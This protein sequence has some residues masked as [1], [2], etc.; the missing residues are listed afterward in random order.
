MKRF[1]AIAFFVTNSLFCMEHFQPYS[2]SPPRP[3]KLTSARSKQ[4]M[5]LRKANDRIEYCGIE[6]YVFQ[7][8]EAARRLSTNPYHQL[9]V[10]IIRA[11]EFEKISKT[12][13]S[14]DER[15]MKNILSGNFI[16]MH[17]MHYDDPSE[18]PHYDFL[19]I[20][21]PNPHKP[22]GKPAHDIP[23]NLPRISNELLLSTLTGEEK[24]RA[25]QLIYQPKEPLQF[26]LEP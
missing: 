5:E 9:T 1:F 20:Q 16:W 6:V 17:W 10:E 18:V 23:D 3:I 11:P 19:I 2:S 15:D 8:L 26:Y 21:E 14:L 12:V 24:T 7:L 13:A 4:Y 25:L 22:S